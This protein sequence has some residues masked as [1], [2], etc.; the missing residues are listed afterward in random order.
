MAESSKL[1]NISVFKFFEMTLEEF[2]SAYN[3]LSED[4]KKILDESICFIHPKVE[5]GEIDQGNGY[6]YAHGKYYT[7]SLDASDI[8]KVLT[9]GDPNEDVVAEVV[10]KTELT[11]MDRIRLKTPSLDW[12]I[13]N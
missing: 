7:M 1:N 10:T 8:Q 5:E 12:V 13:V 9:T 2:K 3:E 4:A 11:P 6:M